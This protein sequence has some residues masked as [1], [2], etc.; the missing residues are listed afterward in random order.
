MPFLKFVCLCA[1]YL[2]HLNPAFAQERTEIDVKYKDFQLSLFPGISSNGLETW[3]YSN[4]Y[5]I[6]L[7]GGLS[8]TNRV[9]EVGAIS[10]LN[11]YGANGIQLAGLANIVGANAYY[12]HDR[13]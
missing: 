13:K 4:K 12:Q 9:L 1:L 11:I 8:A 3:K 2:C 10:N 6:N 7:F 5:S